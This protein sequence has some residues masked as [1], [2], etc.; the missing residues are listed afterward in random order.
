MWL[1]IGIG[2]A[3][4][5]SRAVLNSPFGF[6]YHGIWRAGQQILAGRSPYLAANPRELLVVGN[7]F[8]SPP[9]LAVISIPFSLLPFRVGLVLWDLLCA[10]A[11]AGALCVVGVRDR[12]VY[13]LAGCA[14]P[15]LVSLI[16]GQPDGLFALAAAAA[17]RYRG[18]W[19]GAVAVGILVAAKLLAWPLLLWLVVTRRI[20]CSL[21]AL[22]SVAALLV[23]SW[24]PIGFG[25][26]VDYP[27]LLSADARAFETRSH[28]ITALA[29][30]LGLS[31]TLSTAVTVAVA[32]AI[33]LLIAR[34]ARGSDL[35]WFTAAL[36]LGLFV[37]PM[38]WTHYLLLLFVALAIGRP[39]ADWVW[40]L[41]AT[42]F[43]LS[44]VE[45]AHGWQI[46][47]VLVTAI[48]IA[49]TAGSSPP[50]AP[51]IDDQAV[52]PLTPE[53]LLGASA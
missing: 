45:P 29:M 40:L 6:D 15:F 16:M 49:V 18:S 51:A 11:F 8:V 28:S 41:A 14:F 27:R 17:W 3:V 26:L 4:I 5:L 12:R 1:T 43:V 13:V 24:S 53:H 44:P 50:A 7:S 34:A 38:L 37:S 35:G 52:S 47:L 22:A 46:A 33:A 32:V 20:R 25:G 31:G 2:A 10:A 19:P 48:T 42:A 36:A 23:L 30:R 9:L 21:V 39:T